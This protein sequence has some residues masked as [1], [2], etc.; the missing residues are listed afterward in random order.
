V[1]SAL[2]SKLSNYVFSVTVTDHGDLCV[3]F[4]SGIPIVNKATFHTEGR[5]SVTHFTP[6]KLVLCYGPPVST[7]A[8]DSADPQFISGAG[9]SIILRTTP[10][11]RSTVQ[12]EP[13]NM[14]LCVTH[15]LFACSKKRLQKLWATA[16]CTVAVTLLANAVTVTGVVVPAVSK[17]SDLLAVACM[18]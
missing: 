3:P 13:M 9:V 1:Y 16:F 11:R 6:Y 17:V 2:S 15:M 5:G 7:R 14:H 4:I 8:S 18:R 10:F 12:P